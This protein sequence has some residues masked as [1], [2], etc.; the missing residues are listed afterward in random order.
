[1]VIEISEFGGEHFFLLLQ[2]LNDLLVFILAVLLLQLV[3]LPNMVVVKQAIALL[4]L[5]LDQNLVLE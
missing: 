2:R 4:A 5:R 1:M 3:E